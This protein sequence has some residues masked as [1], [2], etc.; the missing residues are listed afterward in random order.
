MAQHILRRD[1]KKDE[2]RE[3]MVSGLETV[4][5]HQQ[6]MWMVIIAAL[7]V[8][9]AVLG[10]D[11]YSRRQTEKASLV[12]DDALKIFQAP[13]RTPGDPVDPTQVSY[14]DEKNKFT[15]ADKK[16]L[17]VA[18]QYGRTKPGQM[19]EYYAA[20]SEL[21]L[22][23]YADAEKNLS[24]VISGGD[25]NLTSLAKYQLAEVYQQEN[26]GSQAVDLY[27]QLSDKPSIMV[28]KAMSMLAL[29]DYYRK[30]DPAQA[31]KLYNQVK[32]DYPAAAAEADQGLEL[33]NAKS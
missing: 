32:Q 19:A 8:A 28:P 27:K 9:L 21:Q 31:T 14:L 25:E 17:S 7:V 22:K 26:K 5:T 10:W 30:S 3:K 23:N 1:L 4:A 2:I 29:A 24:Q 12:L 15:D 13:I 20:L 6:A 16:F 18:S 33:L 11:T